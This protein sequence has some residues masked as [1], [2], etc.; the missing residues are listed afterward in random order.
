VEENFSLARMARDYVQA[1]GQLLE[2]ASQEKPQPAF[3]A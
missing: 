1:Y 2:G 3:R